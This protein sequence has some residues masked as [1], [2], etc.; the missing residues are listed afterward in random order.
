VIRRAA[1]YARV[2]SAEQAEGTSLDVQEARCRTYAE[3]QGWAVVDTFVDG[4][5]S[6]AKASRPALDTL[7]LEVR[8]QKIDTIVVAKL[9]RFGRSMRHLT[10]VLGE[11]DD[12]GVTLVSVAEGFESSSASGRLQR[13]ILGSFAEFEREVIRD[14]MW[15]GRLASARAGNWPGG[16]APYGWQL[17]R[18]GRATRIEPDPVETDVLRQVVRWLLD[19][20]ISTVQ[21]AQRLNALGV[22]TRKGGPWSHR[23][24]RWILQYGTPLGGRWTFA[25]VSGTRR[26]PGAGLVVLELPE[27]IDAR[28]RAALERLWAATAQGPRPFVRS[29]L[30]TPMASPCGSHYRGQN[31]YSAASYRCAGKPCGCYSVP[32][33]A[34]EAAVWAEVVNLLSDPSRLDLL[35]RRWAD[36]RRSAESVEVSS[37]AS[38][39][40]RIARLERNLHERVAEY[41]RAGLPAESVRSAVGEIEGEVAQLRSH[42]DR[43]AAY[44]AAESGSS[45]RTQR[46]AEL[47]M[48]AR[49]TLAFADSTLRQQVLSLLKIEVAVVGFTVCPTCS[50][51]G[52]VASGHGGVRCRTCAAI[53]YVPSLSVAGE[54]PEALLAS[55]QL[56]AD[57][58]GGA[59]WP[60]GVEV[61]ATGAA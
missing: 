13:N 55:G 56:T 18:E 4:G 7:M 36:T 39:D 49:Q 10:A 16:P 19:E 12:L 20:R 5:V 57:R 9:D 31:Q 58:G 2:S 44:Q 40:R 24:L 22:P 17:V 3:A 14:R 37:V 1:V 29:Y 43:I 23:R 25:P 61:R 30:L 60:F 6:G 15:S 27:L 50:G 45:G 47:A 38:L 26:D 33:D 46:I 8:A 48:A 21:A 51:K 11:L 32:A 54:V 35:A 41:L 34:A 42:R 59:A 52:M 53:R 28:Q